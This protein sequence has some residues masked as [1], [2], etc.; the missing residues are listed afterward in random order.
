MAGYKGWYIGR[1]D[2]A[3]V[4]SVKGGT[5]TAVT[6]TVF[7]WTD[8]KNKPT[9]ATANITGLV[10]ISGGPYPTHDAAYAAANKDPNTTTGTGGKHPPVTDSTVNSSNGHLPNPLSPLETFLG[11]IT[12]LNLW[13]RVAKVLIGGVILTVGLIELTGQSK[14]VK[15]IADKAVK[16][17]PLLL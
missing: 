7:Q 12:S 1:I 3:S 6:D 4:A 17:A 16:A 9:V 10:S 11:D 5:G 13:L 14:N 2:I 15:G 8:D